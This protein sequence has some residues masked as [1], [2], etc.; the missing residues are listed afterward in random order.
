[1]LIWGHFKTNIFSNFS[2]R[3][4]HRPISTENVMSITLSVLGEQLVTFGDHFSIK[5]ENKQILNDKKNSS[6]VISPL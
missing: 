3:R 5:R 1:M 6:A 4:Y 2:T